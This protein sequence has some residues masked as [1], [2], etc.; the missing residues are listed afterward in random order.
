MIYW[1]LLWILKTRVSSGTYSSMVRQRK[2]IPI[3]SFK[4]NNQLIDWYINHKRIRISQW[5]Q[6]KNVRGMMMEM[7]VQPSGMEVRYLLV[8]RHWYKSCLLILLQ[9]T[10]TTATKVMMKALSKNYNNNHN[11]NNNRFESI[12]YQQVISLSI[13]IELLNT[14]LIGRQY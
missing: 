5:Y 9:Q 6:N 10:E 7:V 14:T 4:N 8:D 11:N 3:C 13:R 2:N 12:N 1:W